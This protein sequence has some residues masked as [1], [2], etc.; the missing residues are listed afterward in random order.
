[1]SDV[2][3]FGADWGVPFCTERENEPPSIFWAWA[4][5]G[6]VA[7]EE[8]GDCGG[9]YEYEFFETTLGDFQAWREKPEMSGVRFAM[10]VISSDPEFYAAADMIE[11]FL[12][13]LDAMRA[14]ARAGYDAEIDKF[15]D[16]LLVVPTD[17][18]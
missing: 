1:M 7:L 8:V 11:H 13:D 2:R 6:E 15:S 18:S 16:Q 5:R 17:G 14:A 3:T 10:N 4:P 9:F 12:I